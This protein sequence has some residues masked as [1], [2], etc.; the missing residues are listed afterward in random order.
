MALIKARKG[1]MPCD[2]EA[3]VIEILP[4]EEEESMSGIVNHSLVKN[5]T[6][7]IQVKA[8]KG[9]MD[10]AIANLTVAPAKQRSIYSD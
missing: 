2:K 3:L 1:L 6:C 8:I 9:P 10:H 7:F 5:T 4:P